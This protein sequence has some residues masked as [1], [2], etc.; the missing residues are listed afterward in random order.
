[1]A[2]MLILSRFLAHP[3][4]FLKANEFLKVPGIVFGAHTQVYQV[5]GSILEKKLF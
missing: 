3:G 5:S 1:M 4:G 2:K